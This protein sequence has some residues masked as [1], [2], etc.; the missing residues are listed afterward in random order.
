[1]IL[2]R[3][4]GR[5]CL[6][7]AALNLCGAP[8]QFFLVRGSLRRDR[9]ARRALWHDRQ[10]LQPLE[11]RAHRC[12]WVAEERA[13]ADSGK[14]P[15][16]ALEDCLAGHVLWEL[17]QRVVAVPVAFH[18]ELLPAA[19]HNEVNP[20]V[21][22]FPLRRHAVP[23]PNKSLENHL[24]EGRLKVGSGLSNGPAHAKGILAVLNQPRRRSSGLRSVSAF[25]ECTTHSWSFARLAAT[26]KRC[27]N[28]G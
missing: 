11:H 4:L 1:M 18:S 15:A 3:R 5:T 20:V 17:L 21:A 6:K 22:D 28:F 7:P 16:Q 23:G 9:A 25:R 2:V 14:P 10:L 12:I 19:L 24:L 13:S 8:N 26:L 27:L